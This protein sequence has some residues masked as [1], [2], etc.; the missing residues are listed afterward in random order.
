MQDFMQKL[1]I[2]IILWVIFGFLLDIQFEKLHET[3]L[4]N[5]HMNTMYVKYVMLIA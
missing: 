3:C 4:I 2:F 1:K 5:Q